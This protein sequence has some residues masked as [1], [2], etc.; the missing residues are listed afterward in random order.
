MDIVTP[1][2]RSKMMAAV[3]Q[4]DS[5]PEI[6][7]R[8]MIHAMGYRFRLRRRDLPGTPD[9]VLPRLR[10]V[11][12]VHG[13]YWHRHGC[14]RTTSPRSNSEF[15]QAKFAAN[16]ARDRKVI[17]QLRELGWDSLVVWECQVRRPGWTRE[18]LISFLQR[19]PTAT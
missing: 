11:I 12:F 5:T 9:I 19:R 10:K 17:R 14:R 1:Q 6:A 4:A 15:W 8:L 13:C 7:V 2:V 3:P 16:R 18:R